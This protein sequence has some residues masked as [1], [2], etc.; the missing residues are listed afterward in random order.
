[1][2]RLTGKMILAFQSLIS[3][4][5]I[6]S[7][8]TLIECRKKSEKCTVP[9]K[10]FTSFCKGVKMWE[11]IEMLLLPFYPHFFFSRK[12]PRQGREGWWRWFWWCTCLRF[13]YPEAH[14]HFYPS[15][16]LASCFNVVS[17]FGW[18]IQTGFPPLVMSANTLLDF[19]IRNL[20]E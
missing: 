11:S 6:G 20:G 13:S 2:G 12:V 14:L 9:H 19:S 3:Q 4:W 17:I 15:F 5:H 1:M 7:S 18:S 16:S 8:S 10:N